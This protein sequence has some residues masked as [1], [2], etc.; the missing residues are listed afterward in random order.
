VAEIVG[1]LVVGVQIGADVVG[2]LVLGVLVEDVDFCLW[3]ST[4]WDA[5]LYKSWLRLQIS[6][7]KW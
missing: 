3:K 7:L 2:L 6:K 5:T 1:L 4:L